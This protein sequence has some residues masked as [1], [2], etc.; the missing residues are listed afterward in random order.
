MK[1]TAC[2][3]ALVA[4]LAMSTGALLAYVTVIQR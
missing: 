1:K 3:I 2:L 4:L